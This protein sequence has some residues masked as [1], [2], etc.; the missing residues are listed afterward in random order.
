[1]YIFII[2]NL[3][4]NL[5]SIEDATFNLCRYLSNYFSIN[6]AESVVALFSMGTRRVRIRTGEITKESITDD[7]AKKMINNVGTYLKKK[8]Y[9]EALDCNY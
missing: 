8:N 3:K 1:M 9:Y 4:E 6:M 5:E 7:E 2:D